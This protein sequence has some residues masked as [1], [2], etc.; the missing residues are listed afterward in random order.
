MKMFLLS[1]S[2]T[3]WSFTTWASGER[4]PFFPETEGQRMEYMVTL[5]FGRAHFSGICVMKCLHG[6]IVGTLM[7]EFGLRAFDIRYNPHRGRVM[8]TNLL[9]LLDRWYIRKTLRR[10]LKLLLQ[11]GDPDAPLK[12]RGR[13]I[14]RLD[15]GSLSLNHIRRELNLRFTPLNR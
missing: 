11:N 15:D 5:N 13:R 3:L 8:L 14:E 2:L 1:I 9:D 12:L 6:E 10:D 7:N 4:E